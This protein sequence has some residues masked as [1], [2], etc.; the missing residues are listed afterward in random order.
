MITMSE[1]DTPLGLMLAGATTQGLCLLEFTNRIRLEEEMKNLKAVLKADMQQGRNAHVDQLEKEL[2][3][4]FAGQ[5][6]VFSVAL[7]IP[8]TEFEKT[9][10]MKLQEIPYGRTWSYKKQSILMNNPKAIRAIAATN[11]RNRLAI[12]IPCHRVIGSDGSMT[13]YAAGIEKKKWLLNFER[14]NSEKEP[15][16]LF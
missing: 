11:G 9:V 6:K 4:Y 16:Y 8:G 12:I 7:H 10:W 13:G 5:R 1:I 2:S 15:G 3:E 14:S